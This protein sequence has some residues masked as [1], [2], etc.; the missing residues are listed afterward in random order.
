MFDVVILLVS[1]YILSWGMIILCLIGMALGIRWILKMK[2]DYQVSLIT[3]SKYEIQLIEV[4]LMS[5]YIG[6]LDFEGVLYWFV[7]NLLRFLKAALAFDYKHKEKWQLAY[8]KEVL[9]LNGKVYMKKRFW[10]V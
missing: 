5:L 4:D 6:D 8:K 1:I 3:A 10:R 9:E 2:R 7:G